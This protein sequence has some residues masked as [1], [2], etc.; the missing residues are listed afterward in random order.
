LIQGSTD[1]LAE[2]LLK[3]Y[4]SGNVPF[5]EELWGMNWFKPSERY[6]NMFRKIDKK[7]SIVILNYK[8]VGDTIQCLNSIY[9][10]HY[11]SFQIIVVDNNSQDGSVEKI[12]KWAKENGK[13]MVCC[14]DESIS[15]P[16]ERF[17]QELI[18]IENRE[19]WGFAGGNNMGIR[20]ALECGA[21]YI[22]LLNNDTVIEE[23]ALFELLKSSLINDRIGL[24][25]SKIYLYNDRY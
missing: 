14:K 15:F 18:L 6:R 20:Y 19:N 1:K 3:Y 13:S 8:Q 12:R 7:V 11:K 16:M 21:E 25:S 2:K 10:K 17:N 23:A 5:P 24:I 4:G 9:K 22:W